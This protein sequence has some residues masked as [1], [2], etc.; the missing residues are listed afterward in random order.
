M[1]IGVPVL[2]VDAVRDTGI[3]RLTVIL[4]VTRVFVG[5]EESDFDAFGELLIDAPEDKLC[6]ALAE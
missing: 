6:V 3:E 1:P 4:A 5:V 2:V